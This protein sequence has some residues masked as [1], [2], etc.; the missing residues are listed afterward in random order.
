MS[1][2]QFVQKI[3]CSRRISAWKV[4]ARHD[5][6][7]SCSGMSQLVTL[8]LG[9]RA[10]DNFVHVI[11]RLHMQY[12]KTKNIRLGKL[13]EKLQGDSAGLGPGWG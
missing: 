7:L 1:A 8:E 13:D 10:N 12:I 9:I 3:S 11:C 2:L 6:N 5:V 4:R